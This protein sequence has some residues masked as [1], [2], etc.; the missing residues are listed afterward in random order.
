MK[1]KLLSL[2]L[3]GAMVASTSVSAFAD[4]QDVTVGS[5]GATH[6]VEIE[7]NIADE[8]NATLPGTITVTVPTRVNFTVNSDGQIEGGV[9]NIRNKSKE[10]VEVIAKQ[11][12]DSKPESGIIVK[13][14]FTNDTNTED[15][16]FISLTLEGRNSV[17]LTSDRNNATGLFE[18]ND[19]KS[20]I[21]AENVNTK[22]SLGVIFPE[23]NLSLNL[24]GTAK[25]NSTGDYE[26]PEKAV[27]NNF[28]LTLKIQK[29]KSS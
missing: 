8:N 12:K 21:T 14:D 22:A 24:R 29:A 1:K 10:S 18:L 28:T 26:A 3:A 16:R 27:N 25:G 5:N 15:K 20:D 2:V 7:G 13:K 23:D 19:N 9:I 4:T 11:F 6:P 17:G